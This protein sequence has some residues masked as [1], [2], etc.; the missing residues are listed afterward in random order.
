MRD[1]TRTLSAPRDA[2]T[3][4]PQLVLEISAGPSRG[5]V[6]ALDD[7]RLVL[8]RGEDVDVDLGAVGVSR[9]HARVTCV[10]PG[11]YQL[12]DLGSKNGTFLNDVRVE[13]ASLREG[14]GIR[15]G[16][17]QLVVRRA[18]APGTEPGVPSAREL[19]SARELEIAMLVAR[20]LTNAEVAKRL[21]I[22]R[23][24]VA[25]HLENVYRRL[26]IHSRLVLAVRLLESPDGER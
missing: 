5:R 15:L 6:I 8:G 17:A 2:D 20:G 13:T 18:T 7:G 24:T 9:K 1:K 11:D 25:T 3:A 4:P 14:D 21:S 22:S 23:R 26:G 12:M 16:E 19:L 10:G